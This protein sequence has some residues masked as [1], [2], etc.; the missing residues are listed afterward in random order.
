MKKFFAMALAL[1]LCL[2]G[3]AQAATV[4]FKLYISQ[5]GGVGSYQ[6]RAS[7]SPG[8]NFGIAS[9]GVELVGNGTSILTANHNSIRSAFA[10]RTSDNAEGTAGFTFLRSADQAA[11]SAFANISASQDTTGGTP[12]AIY[13]LGQEAGS[14]ASEGLVG[15]AQEGNPWD[16]EI[17]LAQGTYTPR[18]GSGP[19]TG[20]ARGIDFID[21][22]GDPTGISFANVFNTNTGQTTEAALM[23]FQVIPEPATIAMA[24]MGLIGCV[25]VAAR[26]RNG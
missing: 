22:L 2:G 17:L 11:A 5:S 23:E 13:G 15:S 18:A 16:A 1:S 14:L 12:I 9:Y 8:D 21:T 10:T 20:I 24:G 19:L 26:R 7:S 25:V 4:T 3:A 6:L